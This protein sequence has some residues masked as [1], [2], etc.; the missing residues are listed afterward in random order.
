MQID[1][2]Y[3]YTNITL[4]N[5]YSAPEILAKNKVRAESDFYTLGTFM[6]EMM[7]QKVFSFNNE[8]ENLRIRTWR[9]RKCGKSSH[10][11]TINLTEKVQSS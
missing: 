1:T 11:G 6:Y 3:E 9:T 10:N 4:P 7:T 8:S 2:I 5:V